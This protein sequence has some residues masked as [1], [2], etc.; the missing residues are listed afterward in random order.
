[1]IVVY[2]KSSGS[3]RHL[4][5]LKKLFTQQDV[6]VDEFISV[7]ADLAV[8]IQKGETIAVIGG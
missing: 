4:D 2:N 7:D 6:A 1:M 3:A 8:Y 5:E